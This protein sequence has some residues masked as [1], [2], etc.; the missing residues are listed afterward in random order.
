MAFPKLLIISLLFSYAT[1]AFA[2]PEQFY[3]AAIQ[4]TALHQE[5]PNDPQSLTTIE[6]SHVRMVTFTN[7]T[8]YK[9][10]DTQLGANVWMT[11]DPELKN[12]CMQFTKTHP[13]AT[14]EQ[15]T[16]WIAE[17]LGLSP[18][19]VETRQFV[20]FDVPVI[21]AFYGN[22][23]NTIGIFRPCTDPR[24]GLH[25]DGSLTCP[26]TM[27]N[28]DKNIPSDYKTWFIDN[29]LSAYT[30]EKKNQHDIGAPWTGYGYTYNWNPASAYFG[31]SEF[32]ALKNTPVTVLA[33][34]F[35]TNTAYITPE[36]YCGV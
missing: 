3:T 5:N 28:D 35:D 13:H 12:Q 33:S 22:P 7:Y 14:H 21:Q 36:Q 27:N 31:L 16:L 4:T 30:L 9:T 10:T 17:L 20:V 25:T 32:V 34:P 23:E 6:G 24:I 2:D 29:G 26:V 11:V 1:F 15:L 19:Q 18:Y 8:G